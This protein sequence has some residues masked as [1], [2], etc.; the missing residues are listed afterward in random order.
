MQAADENMQRKEQQQPCRPDP[1]IPKE[2]DLPDPVTAQKTINDEQQDMHV[3]LI[4]DIADG[5]RDRLDLFLV[6]ARNALTG[7]FL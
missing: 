3:L 4:F 1:A 6:D 7:K 2:G 5:G